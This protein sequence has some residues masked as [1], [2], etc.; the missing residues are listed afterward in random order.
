L[1]ARVHDEVR[2]PGRA[3]E[4]PLDREPASAAVADELDDAGQ[5]TFALPMQLEPALDRLAAVAGK[6]DVV[7]LDGFEAEVHALELGIER[8]SA[9]LGERLFPERREVLRFLALRFVGLE[10]VE[11][12]VEEGH[13]D[14][15]LVKT[16]PKTAGA[17]LKASAPWF[18]IGRVA[19]D[20][21]LAEL[22]LDVNAVELQAGDVGA[23]EALAGDAF[24]ADGHFRAVTTGFV[25]HGDMDIVKGEPLDRLLRETEHERGCAAS[26]DGSDLAK[27]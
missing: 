18:L 24:D 22:V 15:L 20:K 14:L 13:G 5:G 1:A 21:R 12:F 9:G 17:I 6:G 8:M 3:P 26:L 2:V 11:W 10:L 4:Q 23:V 25:G 16:G 27:G 19:Q 7:A